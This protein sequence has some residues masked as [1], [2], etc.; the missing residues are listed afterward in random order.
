L[1]VIRKPIETIPK[2]LHSAYMEPPDIRSLAH[3]K[4]GW[5]ALAMP[6]NPLA[7]VGLLLPL[8][9]GACGLSVS[10]DNVYTL[11]RTSP[12]LD[13]S[14][15]LRRVHVA[16]FDAKGGEQ[17]NQKNCDIARQLFQAQPGIIVRYWCEKG[18][19]RQ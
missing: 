8:T 2:N 10:N 18:G 15:E 16:T 11:Y 9:L 12:V 13:S 17:Y 6:H 1:P 7:A 14:P 4:P 3:A 5:H 19:F